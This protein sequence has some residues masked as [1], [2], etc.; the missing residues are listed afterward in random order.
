MNTNPKSNPKRKTRRAPPKP[1]VG[2]EGAPHDRVAAAGFPPPATAPNE[3]LERPSMT[4]EVADGERDIG[5]V[6]HGSG[7]FESV[8]R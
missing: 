8:D 2:A 4:S 1:E 6:P 7:R 3:P 5:S